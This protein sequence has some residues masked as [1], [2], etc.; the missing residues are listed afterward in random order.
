MIAD[1][2]TLGLALVM[3]LPLLNYLRISSRAPL[4][5]TACLVVIGL[6][7]L[8]VIGTYSRG[9]L[10]AMGA[11][12]AAYAIRS[13]SG[14]VL[15][16]LAAI[17]TISA[18]TF[19][20]SSWLDRMATIRSYEEDASFAGRVAAWKTS[21]NIAEA[22]PLVGAGYSAVNLD[23]VVQQFETAGSLRSGKAAHSIYFEVLGDHGFVGLA[24]YIAMLTAAWLNTSLVLNATRGK[25]D[26][27]WANQLARMLRLSMV[28]Y[29]VGG[30][31]LSM[32]YYDGFLI[33]LAVTAALLQ[34]VRQPVV[35]YAEPILEPRWKRIAAVAAAPRWTR[36]APATVEPVWRRRKEKFAE[37]SSHP[38]SIK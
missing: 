20:P 18:P 8:A 25:P 11:A 10:L 31:A 38:S 35:E 22:R 14:L 29:L 19:L 16:T 34:T 6:T 13:R 3:L 28:A 26:L 21:V 32:A 27:D 17:L 33:V 12:G 5:R 24:I 4:T 2:N 30:A 23:K 7:V 1:N 15:A 9:A 36:P 37:A